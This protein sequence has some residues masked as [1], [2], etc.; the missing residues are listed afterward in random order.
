MSAQEV[1]I[2]VILLLLAPTLLAATPALAP[3]E[4]R[5]MVELAQV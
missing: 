5:E 1:L 2:S 4:L 3:R